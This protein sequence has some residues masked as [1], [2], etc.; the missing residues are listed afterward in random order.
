MGHHITAQIIY[1]R[2]IRTCRYEG[3]PIVY[4]DETYNHGLHT[5]FEWIDDKLHGQK[6]KYQ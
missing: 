2:C 3:R 1:F 5:P 6:D 4:M